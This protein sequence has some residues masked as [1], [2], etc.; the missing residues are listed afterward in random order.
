[1]I[2]DKPVVEETTLSE[3][4]LHE[5]LLPWLRGNV[6]HGTTHAGFE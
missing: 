4:V 5:E 1:M 2:Q 6:F 3:E